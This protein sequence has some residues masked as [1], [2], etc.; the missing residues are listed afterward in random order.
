MLLLIIIIVYII[1]K[2]P[3]G[4]LRC[5]YLLSLNKTFTMI[6]TT[7]IY[8]ITNCYNNPNNVYI[9]KTINVINREYNH[10]IRFGDQIQ[11]SIIDETDMD[12]KSLESYWIEQFKHWGFNILNKNRGG[13]G[14]EYRTEDEKSRISKSKTGYKHSEY[15]KHKMSLSNSK[16]KPDGFGIKLRKPKSVPQNHK[17]ILQYDLEGNFIQEWGSGK[18]ASNNLKI[19]HS[20][21]SECCKGK[22]KSS[23]GFIWKHKT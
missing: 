12:W 5:R 14:P 6:H 3:Y 17:P 16:P 4:A 22:Y 11:F 21:I 19:S 20:G 10:K 8:L 15:T 23:G 2:A 18:I 7:K 1:D 9:G 13:G